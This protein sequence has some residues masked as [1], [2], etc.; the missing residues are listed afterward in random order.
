[1]TGPAGL[2]HVTTGLGSLD[3]RQ[4]NRYLARRGAGGVN[5]GSGQA[6]RPAGPVTL[7]RRA[8]KRRHRRTARP[9]EQG[10]PHNEHAEV[11]VRGHTQAATTRKE[12]PCPTRL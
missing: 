12:L 6:A 5:S 9:V 8:R 4:R 1:M 11:A 10:T 7:V 2:G 3:M